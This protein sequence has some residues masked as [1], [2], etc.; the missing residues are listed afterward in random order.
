MSYN[1]PNTL[2]TDFFARFKRR[3]TAGASAGASRDDMERENDR[4]L[5]FMSERV[6]ALKNVTID[7]NEEVSRQHLLLDETAD[8]FARVRETLRDSARAFQRVIDNAR[9]QGYFWQVVMFVIVSFFILRMM[10]Y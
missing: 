10:F 5:E 7:I 3:N 9:R 8:E 2:E 4:S 1:R 6:S